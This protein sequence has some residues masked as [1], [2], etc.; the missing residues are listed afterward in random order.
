M[1]GWPWRV[2]YWTCVRPGSSN[3]HAILTQRPCAMTISHIK[4]AGM[5]MRCAKAECRRRAKIFFL[6]TFFLTALLFSLF[7]SCWV[8]HSLTSSSSSCWSD[9]SRNQTGTDQARPGQSSQRQRSPLDYACTY[10]A[11]SSTYGAICDVRR[12]MDH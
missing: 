4:N 5:K 9:D 6:L 7:E 8:R 1:A 2:L 10:G 11:G 12:S 3:L